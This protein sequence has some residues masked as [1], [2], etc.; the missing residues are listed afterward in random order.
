M[1]HQVGMP[2][3]NPDFLRFLSWPDGDLRISNERTF[4]WSH[5]ITK[6]LKLCN[7][8][9]CQ[10]KR[11]SCKAWAAD[12]LRKNFYVDDFLLLEESEK[13]AVQRISSVHSAFAA[14]GFTLGN[15]AS[16]RREVLVT[17]PQEERA[18]DVRTLD[19]TTDHLQ[20]ERA[21]GVQWAV[22]SD[23]L[24]F[25]I[26]LKDKPFTQTGI[27]STIC[28]VYDPLGIAAPLYWLG[29]RFY[30]ISVAWSSDGMMK[31]MKNSAQAGKTGEDSFQ[32]WHVSP[33]TVGSSLLIL[34][35][36][37]QGNY[38]AS[39]MAAHPAMDKEHI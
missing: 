13:A 4:I 3:Y 17:V 34:V 31:L 10:T 8:K 11:E 16:N 18:Q 2:V 32:L 14:R 22:E 21:L 37:S 20:V 19:L 39:P 9:S 35:Q 27:L 23:T 6:L 26:I 30:K 24:W 25:W 7:E 15:F 33:W 5:F 29:R 28:S 38:T 1:F 36:S 12:I